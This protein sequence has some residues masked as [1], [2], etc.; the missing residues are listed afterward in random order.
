M[1]LIT[2]VQARLRIVRSVSTRPG[3][4]RKDRTG[5]TTGTRNANFF[6][7]SERDSLRY[8]LD[9]GLGDDAANR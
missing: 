2:G 3:S 8:R 7:G 6:R 9:G 5:A 4:L 1:H